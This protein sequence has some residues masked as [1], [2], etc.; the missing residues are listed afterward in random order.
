ML[1]MLTETVAIKSVTVGQDST[2]RTDRRPSHLS[3]GKRFFIRA[4]HCVCFPSEKGSHA[5]ARR[6]DWR[7]DPSFY[8]AEFKDT[9][10][11]VLYVEN[12]FS[13]AQASARN[14]M[15]RLQVHFCQIIWLVQQPSGSWP[16]ISNVVVP[17]VVVHPQN[18]LGRHHPFV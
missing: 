18:H 12:W 13:S 4:F 6:C 2:Q 14:E 3:R 5:L 17:I 8:P 16:P 7:S 15:P 10:L 11:L 1:V 9:A